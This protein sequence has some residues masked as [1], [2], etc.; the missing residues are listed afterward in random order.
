MR[1]VYAN[2]IGMK[3]TQGEIVLEFGA[4]FPDKPAVGPPS[5]YKPEVQVVLQLAAIDGLQGGL[6]QIKQ[7]IVQNQQK[8]TGTQK[9]ATPLGFQKPSKLMP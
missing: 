4:F 6:N 5:D 7:T 8:G 1:V 2:V 9:P 3:L